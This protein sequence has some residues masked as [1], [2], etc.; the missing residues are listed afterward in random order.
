MKRTI[1]FTLA[2]I[3][4]LPTSSFAHKPKNMDISFNGRTQQLNVTVSHSTTNP[5]I[6]YI[7]QLDIMVN[8]ELVKTQSITG[9]ENTSTGLSYTD[10]LRGVQSGDQIS[11]T[12]SCSR[13][14]TFKGGIV[15][16]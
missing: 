3:L 6:H 8:D 4:I 16:Q 5:N 2:V 1:L 11:V 7:Y 9:K 10:L 13:G 15:V 14:G 12:A